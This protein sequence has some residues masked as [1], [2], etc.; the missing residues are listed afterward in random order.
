MNW[1]ADVIGTNGETA[2]MFA[3]SSPAFIVQF[4]TNPLVFNPFKKKLLKK[5]EGIHLHFIQQKYSKNLKM[6]R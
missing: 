1:P 6:L 3:G 4:G 5:F 2:Y